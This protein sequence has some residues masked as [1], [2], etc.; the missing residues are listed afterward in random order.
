MRAIKWENFTSLFANG[1]ANVTRDRLLTGRCYYGHD[2]A[3]AYRCRNVARPAPSSPE[4]NDPQGLCV[5]VHDEKKTR[6][7]LG[8][9][10]H[11]IAIVCWVLDLNMHL[12]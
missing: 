1:F 7:G 12:L 2:D 3:S 6:Q 8:A 9:R 4:K 11:S 5:C 10:F